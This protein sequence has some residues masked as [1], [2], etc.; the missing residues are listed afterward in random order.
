MKWAHL[1]LLLAVSACKRTEPPPQRKGPSPDAQTTLSAQPANGTRAAPA[2]S[3]AVPV[4]ACDTTFGAPGDALGALPSTLEATV[5]P[6]LS[7]A[8][9]GDGSSFVL[10]PVGWICKAAVGADGSE[11]LTVAP[12]GSGDAPD[13]AVTADLSGPCQGC[14]GSIACP[15]FPDAGVGIPCGSPAPDGE[16]IARQSATD[17]VFEDP[18]RVAGTGRPSGGDNPANG[19]VIYL[20]AGADGQAAVTET[21]TMPESD[22]AICQTILNDFLT[23]SRPQ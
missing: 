4:V 23:R 3:S 22:H 17:V 10:A 11:S 8:F 16:R 2:G 7:V 14:A 5:P 1:S 20:A 18:P 15:F 9:Y 13:Q 19:V 6:G 21:C 12:R